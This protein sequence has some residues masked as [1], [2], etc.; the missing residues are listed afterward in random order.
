MMGHLK[1]QRW[2][3]TA[4][5]LRVI[6]AILQNYDIN[7]L[8]FP[9]HSSFT[10]INDTALEQLS[11]DFRE[12]QGEYLIEGQTSPVRCDRQVTLLPQPIYIPP[13][14]VQEHLT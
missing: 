8:P 2:R 9:V 3:L 10:P 6:I 11:L 4:R 13:F 12:E 1:G 14:L 7:Q 5:A